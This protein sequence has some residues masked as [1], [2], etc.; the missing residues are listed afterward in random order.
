MGSLLTILVG[1]A[2]VLGAPYLVRQASGL[3]GYA[4]DAVDQGCTVQHRLQIAMM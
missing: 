3:V 4:A 1:F 2:V